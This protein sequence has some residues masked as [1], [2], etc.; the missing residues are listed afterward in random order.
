MPI[1]KEVIEVSVFNHLVGIKDKELI[2]LKGHLLLDVM[3]SEATKNEKYGFH[4]KVGIFSNICKDDEVVNLLYDLNN[5]R[6]M[7]AHEWD[8]E[9]ESSGLIEWSEN[10]L[11]KTKSTM[12]SRRT[13]RM[14][15][16]KAIASLSRE[17]YVFSL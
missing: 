11:E 14:D 15:L 17:V 12:A 8:F 16:V 9:I 6:N 4:G 7:L 10:V 13:Q 3:L 2:L 1:P 5:I